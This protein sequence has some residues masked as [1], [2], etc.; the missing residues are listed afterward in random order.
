M[1]KKNVSILFVDDDR[2][3]LHSTAEWLRT[4]GYTVLTAE[5]AREARTTLEEKRGEIP[6]A[7]LDLQ[8]GAESGMELLRD[9]VYRYPN[10]TCIMLSGHASI[11]LAVEALHAGAADFLTKPLLDEKIIHTIEKYADGQ[12][13]ARYASSAFRSNDGTGGVANF[14]GIVG[15][16]RR[17]RAVFDV[18]DRIADTRATVLLTGESGTGKSLIARAIHKKS[19]RKAEPFVEVACGALPESLLESE[20]F[21]HAA[22]AFTGAIGEK[23]GKFRQADRGTIFLDEIGTAS[24]AMQIKLLRVLQEF[25]FEPVGGTKTFHVDTRVVLATNED[26]SRAV[27]EGRFREDLFYR[28]NVISIEIPALR[29]RADDIPLLADFFREK[30]CRESHRRVE[31]FTDEALGLMKMYSWPGNVRELQNV[32][33]RMVLLTRNRRIEPSDLPS[34]VIPAAGIPKR[35]R[36]AEELL[37]MPLALGDRPL[38]ESLGVPEREIILETLVANHWCRTKTAQVLGI[39]RAT[40]YKKMKKFELSE[41]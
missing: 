9:I 19:L 12:N 4:Y 31:A 20:L 22:G 6:L 17:M 40:L 39:N 38:R 37:E 34:A 14:G 10:T 27:A 5:N 2:H 23:I 15:A 24:I 18:I 11:E 13:T 29:Y 32:V 35:W 8:L 33:E 25:E 21:G 16:N 28:I 26:L 41:K 7:F 30:A 1:A 3:V 36:R